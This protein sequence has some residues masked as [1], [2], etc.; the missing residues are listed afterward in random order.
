MQ[1]QSRLEKIKIYKRLCKLKIFSQSNS[2]VLM[3]ANGAKT[4]LYYNP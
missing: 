2:C 4:K 3:T 1:I